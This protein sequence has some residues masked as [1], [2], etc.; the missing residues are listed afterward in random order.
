M[1]RARKLAS[2]MIEQ[3]CKSVEIVQAYMLLA[4]YNSPT[5][6]FEDDR[7]YTYSGIA[8]RMAVELNLWRNPKLPGNLDEEATAAFQAEAMNRERTWFQM[9]MLDVGDS[10]NLNGI[11]EC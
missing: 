11:K 5:E 10:A 4:Y 1:P 7:T 2:E 8:I 6:R 3:G 9:F